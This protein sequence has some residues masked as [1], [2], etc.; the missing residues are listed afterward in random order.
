MEN[1]YQEKFTFEIR[2]SQINLR[3]QKNF[4]WPRWHQVNLGGSK[5]NQ[6]RSFLP[7][8][9]LSN[10][11][12]RW[13]KG[14]QISSTLQWL[15][16]PGFPLSSSASGNFGLLKGRIIVKAEHNSYGNTSQYLWEQPESDSSRPVL[17]PC[18][19]SNR[20][21]SISILFASDRIANYFDPTRR[22][23][24]FKEADCCR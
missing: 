9:L 18:A 20:N 7:A 6:V 1:A 23:H 10:F 15:L 14:L 17:L 11:S 3:S 2:W 24:P 19:R 22:V 13:Q 21:S 8:N 5:W 4:S 16:P 12:C